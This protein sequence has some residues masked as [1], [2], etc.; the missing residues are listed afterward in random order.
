MYIPTGEYMPVKKGKFME[1]FVRKL[2]KF[3]H[4]NNLIH[5]GDR[6]GA[7]LS[8]GIDSMVLACTLINIRKNLDCEII[9]LHL[10]H[11][12]RNEESDS[13]EDFVREWAYKWE[14]P[15]I[16]RKVDA[17][18]FSHEKGYSLEEGCRELRYAFFGEIASNEQLMSVATGHNQDDQAETILLHLLR[19]AGRQGLSGIRP[20]REPHYIRPLLWASRNDIEKYA[21][22]MKL[23]HREDSSNTDLRFTRN[24]IRHILLPLLEREYVIGIKKILSREAEILNIEEDFL[25]IVTHDSLQTVTR[26]SSNRKNVLDYWGFC[27]YHESLRRRMILDILKRLKPESRDI[28]YALVDRILEC[29]ESGKNSYFDTGQDIIVEI[30]DEEIIFYRAFNEALDVMIDFPGKN[31]LGLN[32]GTLNASVLKGMPDFTELNDNGN[33]AVFDSKICIYEKGNLRVTFLKKGD[34]IK[35][36]GHRG[37]RKITDILSEKGIPRVYRNDIPILRG[38]GGRVLWV[39]GIK[40][41]VFYSVGKDT[42]SVIKLVYNRSNEYN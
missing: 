41:S 1:H 21:R 35:P 30:T 31:N 12:L 40:R 16:S 27:S 19:G 23:P 3:I 36:F 14:V 7:A 32:L 2:L 9:L 15:L 33:I 17:E 11:G 8:G 28:D 5:T 13:D 29:L 39:P 4:T 6:I 42:K 10:N 25:K 37:S 18:A 38:V 34:R 20:F 22:Q 24:K 26:E